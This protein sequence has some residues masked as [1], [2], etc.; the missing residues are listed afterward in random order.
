MKSTTKT[1]VVGKPKVQKIMLKK[2]DLKYF[3]DSYK[4]ST[5]LYNISYDKKYEN[6]TIK[7]FLEDV[8]FYNKGN[9]NNWIIPNN[10]PYSDD[11]SYEISKLYSCAGINIPLKQGALYKQNTDLFALHLNELH[12]KSSKF[13][14]VNAIIFGKRVNKIREDFTSHKQYILDDILDTH[15]NKTLTCEFMS[16]QKD[17]CCQIIVNAVNNARRN[18]KTGLINMSSI[19]IDAKDANN[20]QFGLPL[21]LNNYNTYKIHTNNPQLYNPHLYNKSTTK[22]TVVWQINLF[23]VTKPSLDDIGHLAIGCLNRL[24]LKPKDPK[25]AVDID[26]AYLYG[27]L[28]TQLNKFIE[29]LRPYFRFFDN[30]EMIM[31][32]KEHNIRRTKDSIDNFVKMDPGINKLYSYYE[33]EYD[34]L[35][36]MQE[37]IDYKSYS[38]YLIAL[39]LY[40]IATEDVK[41]TESQSKYFS[42]LPLNKNY[43]EYDESSLKTISIT[44]LFR[45][46]RKKYMKSIHHLTLDKNRLIPAS[47]IEEIDLLKYIIYHSTDSINYKNTFSRHIEL[48]TVGWEHKYTGPGKYVKIIPPNPNSVLVTGELNLSR[49]E[50]T[51]LRTSVKILD[52]EPEIVEIKTEDP[53][54]QIAK[55]ANTEI[56]NVNSG[57]EVIGHKI[58]SPIPYFILDPTSIIPSNIEYYDLKYGHRDLNFE[59]L[60]T[61]FIKYRTQALNMMADFDLCNDSFGLH[62]RKKFLDDGPLLIMNINGIDAHIYTS[63]NAKQRYIILKEDPQMIMFVIYDNVTE[64]YKID[65]TSTINKYMN[66]IEFYYGYI[67]SRDITKL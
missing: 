54:I 50:I 33:K 5:D 60:D 2:P 7:E 30:V 21:M 59:N 23:D 38:H 29:V 22:K 37:V 45:I 47:E 25:F 6:L 66:I 67:W 11:I 63:P 15:L 26:F 1:T 55:L 9:K 28:V 19:N 41:I 49:Q 34:E 35:K 18:L 16:Y 10:K 27:G 61:S 56:Q 58:I 64:Q 4:L 24:Q 43:I 20:L 44:Q 8:V 51:D 53:E 31:F 17:V 62:L 65:D 46:I 3:E 12:P 13:Y 57:V 52:N 40:H 14:K 39:Y 42:Y 32:C 48:G 36:N